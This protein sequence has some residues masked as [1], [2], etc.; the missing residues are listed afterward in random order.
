MLML[1][2]TNERQAEQPHLFGPNLKGF[3]K[4]KRVIISSELQLL[5]SSAAVT[6]SSQGSQEAAAVQQAGLQTNR[7]QER[8]A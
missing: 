8:Q 1:G 4:R 2:L 7:L 5:S 6:I 3:I